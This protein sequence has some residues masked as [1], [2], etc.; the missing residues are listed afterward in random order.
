MKIFAQRLRELRNEKDMSQKQIA[1][2]LRI[3]QQSY[4][5]YEMDT[6]EP[7]Y[8]MLVEIAKYFGVSTDYLLGISDY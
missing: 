7:C 6:S 8:D 5:R 4:A 2:V 3:R 1:D